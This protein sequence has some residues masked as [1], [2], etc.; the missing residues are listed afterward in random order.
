MFLV[1]VETFIIRL[2]MLITDK[3]YVNPLNEQ[4]FQKISKQLNKKTFSSSDSGA[5]SIRYSKALIIKRFLS[6]NL[7]HAVVEPSYI[8][9]CQ[10]TSLCRKMHCV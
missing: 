7:L 6:L 8:K 3:L 2:K 5:K 4:D 1:E 10:L 9:E